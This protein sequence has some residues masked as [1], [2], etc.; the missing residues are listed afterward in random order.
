MPSAESAAWIESKKASD[1]ARRCCRGAHVA[2]DAAP[3]AVREVGADAILSTRSP[4]AR[5]GERAQRSSPSGAESH[6]LPKAPHT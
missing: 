3:I 5:T 1:M 2:S 6:G 4:T